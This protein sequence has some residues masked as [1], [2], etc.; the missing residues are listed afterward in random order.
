MALSSMTAALFDANLDKADGCLVGAERR[1]ATGE[2]GLVNRPEMVTRRD[3]ADRMTLTS[4][5]A[6]NSICMHI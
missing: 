3:Q 5:H 2:A 1:L 6:D 4:R